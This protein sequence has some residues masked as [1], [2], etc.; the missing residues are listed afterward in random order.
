M[1]TPETAPLV[2]PSRRLEILAA[3]FNTED[4]T[5]HVGIM[6]YKGASLEVETSPF[7]FPTIWKSI[8]PNPVDDDDDASIFTYLPGFNRLIP[9]MPAQKLHRFDALSFI[10]A[11]GD[12]RGLFVSRCPGRN[13]TLGP[14]DWQSCE[15]VS[16][17]IPPK[18]PDDA[19]I[20]IQ[21]IV[22][23]TLV[24]S[25]PEAFEY[26]YETSKTPS[27][28]LKWDPDLFK[29][30]QGSAGRDYGF[31]CIYYIIEGEK[32]VRNLTGK[33]GTTT[34]WPLLGL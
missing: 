21:A 34:K 31:A 19:P 10:F 18:Q 9:K 27:K 29:C 11:D 24:I 13:A 22:Y 26:A 25:D 1:I 12:K 28:E 7:I 6:F 30:P 4:V 14:D 15:N 17:C 20:H 33:S 32:R 2:R 8:L 23:G 16:E 3:T 5:D